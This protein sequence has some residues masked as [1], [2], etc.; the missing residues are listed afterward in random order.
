MN[1]RWKVTTLDGFGRVIQVDSGHDATP[2][3]NPISRVQTQY[4]LCACSP[5]GK[6]WKVSQPYNPSSGTPVWTTYSYDALGRTVNVV[7]ADAAS[8][9]QTQYTGNHTKVI[10]PAGKWK[11]STVDA[12]GNLT[13]VTEP[14]P[15]GGANLTT[16]YT[17]SLLNQLLTLR[18]D[19]TRKRPARVPASLI[20]WHA[21]GARDWL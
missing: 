5:L 18:E 8:N 11:T 12:F 4:A 10:D 21:V 17:Y 6:L 19:I 7:A 20:G 16:T 13:L 9:T 15:A 3:N 1:G 2:G 14:N